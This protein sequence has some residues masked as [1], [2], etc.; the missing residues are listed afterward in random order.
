MADPVAS[1]PWQLEQFSSNNVR[2]GAM[3]EEGGS[4]YEIGEPGVPGGTP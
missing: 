1:V 2:P 4:E 3:Y